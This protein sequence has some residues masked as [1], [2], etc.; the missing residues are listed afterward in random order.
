[1]KITI[2]PKD[3][4]V[5]VDGKG[6]IGIDMSGAP[7]NIHA[8]QFDSPY[9][10]TEYNDG[11]PNSIIASISPFQFLVDRY[12]VALAEQIERETN[13]YYGMSL[14]EA[15]QAKCNKV[16]NLAETA[17]RKV[18]DSG[19]N[20]LNPDGLQTM[21]ELLLHALLVKAQNDDAW[22]VNVI[23]SNTDADGVPDRVELSAAQVID[24]IKDIKQRNENIN[25]TA[26]DHKDNILRLTSVEDVKN[27][28]LPSI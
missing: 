15:K 21:E 8:V 9:G 14:E 12:N 16:D 18:Y 27:Y 26:Q 24:K 19:A 10:H 7:E 1:M 25:Q 6:L 13:P 3:G 22:R 11:T 17:K 20:K 28:P 5:S 2:I 4:F 23:L